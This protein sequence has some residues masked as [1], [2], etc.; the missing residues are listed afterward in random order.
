MSWMIES[1]VSRGRSHIN[2]TRW[3]EYSLD[4]RGKLLSQISVMVRNR[5]MP[6]PKYLILHPEA[7]ISDA[8]IAQLNEWAR[9]ERRRMK[10]L[11]T[12]EEN[13]PSGGSQ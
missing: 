2:L 13:V 1:D 9:A 5:A 3:S 7:R 12:Q 6:L 10:L 11:A 4:E 8:E